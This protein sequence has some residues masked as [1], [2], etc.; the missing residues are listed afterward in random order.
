MFAQ[1]V[2]TF[3][4][5][6]A[7]PLSWK[8]E[9][10]PSISLATLFYALTTSPEE[11][12]CSAARGGIYDAEESTDWTS[13]GTWQLG[14]SY[15]GYGGNGNYGRDLIN[16]QSP[17]TSEPFT[18]D[19]VLIA[20]INTTQYLTGLFGLGITQGNFNGTVAESPM[21]QAVSEYG[22]IP[23]YSFGYTAGAHYS[24]L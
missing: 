22:L 10:S 21:T 3:F 16:T 18:M 19:N 17:L 23:S 12:H 7:C 9:T 20:S 15:L 6:K 8:V 4:V 14:L 2:Y 1:Y 24:T 5:S 13:L 11:P